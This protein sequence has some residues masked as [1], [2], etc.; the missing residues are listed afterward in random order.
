MSVNSHNRAARPGR[1]AKH[2]PAGPTASVEKCHSARKSEPV[3]K[4]VL[5]VCGQPT[6]LS[7]ILP[8][9]FAADLRIQ[10]NLEISVVGVVLALANQRFYFGTL[11]HLT[12]ACPLSMRCERNQKLPKPDGRRLSG[13]L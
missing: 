3:Q 4:L 10:F 5:L 1:R 2:R 9:S 6:V 12:S 11:F 7:D 13:S 8:E